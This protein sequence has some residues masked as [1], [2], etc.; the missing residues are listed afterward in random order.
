LTTNREKAEAVALWVNAKF[1]NQVAPWV[2][3]QLVQIGYLFAKE[4]GIVK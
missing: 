4:K 2:I 3:V 1:G